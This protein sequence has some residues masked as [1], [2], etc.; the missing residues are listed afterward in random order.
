M[1]TSRSDASTTV[2]VN[3]NRYVLREGAYSNPT[4]AAVPFTTVKEGDFAI[5]Q[6]FPTTNG[7]LIATIDG[8]PDSMYFDLVRI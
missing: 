7:N 6:V 3:G 2:L 1:A 4:G 8:Y 5:A